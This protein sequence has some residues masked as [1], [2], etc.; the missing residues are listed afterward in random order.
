MDVLENR[1]EAVCRS[2]VQF[3]KLFLIFQKTAGMRRKSERVKPFRLEMIL[4]PVFDS[5]DSLQKV[6]LR[7]RQILA[8]SS[9]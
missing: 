2:A 9:L 1:S 4:M 7:L 6:G 5:D 8:R 3:L